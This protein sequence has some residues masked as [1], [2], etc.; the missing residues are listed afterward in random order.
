MHTACA[1]LGFGLAER[2]GIP[3][4]G[5]SSLS[6]RSQRCDSGPDDDGGEMCSAYVIMDVRCIIALLEVS[7]KQ[8]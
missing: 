6:Q 4:D 8:G 3:L 5:L 7:V 2:E 1:A